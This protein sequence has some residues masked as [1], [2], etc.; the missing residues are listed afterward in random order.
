MQEQLGPERE[1]RGRPWT[2]SVPGSSVGVKALA[3]HRANPG[4]TTQEPKTAMFLFP[5]PLHTQRKKIREAGRKHVQV[6][7]TLGREAV[8]V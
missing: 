1:D 3:W 6:R 7:P 2:G 8:M 5:E 4:L